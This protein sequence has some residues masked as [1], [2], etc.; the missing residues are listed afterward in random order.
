MKEKSRFMAQD[1]KQRID[2]G[3]TQDGL[4]S[5]GVF[6]GLRRTL[7]NHVTGLGFDSDVFRAGVFAD[8]LN[9]AFNRLDG[10]S[11]AVEE[12]IAPFYRRRIRILPHAD[13]VTITVPFRGEEEQTVTIG[14]QDLKQLIEK[15]RELIARIKD[16]EDN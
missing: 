1:F 8:K 15:L 11:N 5:F 3:I 2:L 7:D 9:E 16:E 12:L 10:K 14:K 4:I 6:T 13:V